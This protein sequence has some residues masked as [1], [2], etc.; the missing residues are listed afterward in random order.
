MAARAEAPK[1]KATIASPNI[2]KKRFHSI[3]DNREFENCCFQTISKETMTSLE[4]LR[5]LSD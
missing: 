1:A 4:Q 2:S 3:V 5:Q